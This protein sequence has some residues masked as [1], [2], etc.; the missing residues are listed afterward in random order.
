M[1]TITAILSACFDNASTMLLVAPTLIKLGELEHIDPRYMLLIA[2][3]FSNIG[4]C[5]TP[6]GDPPNLIIFGSPFVG[7]LQISYGTFVCYASPCVIITM[8]VIGVYLKLVYKSKESFR[9]A[10]PPVDDE[11]AQHTTCTS[12]P[13][14]VSGPQEV[15][16]ANTNV[17]KSP[18]QSAGDPIQSTSVVITSESNGRSADTGKRGSQVD[19][20]VDAL[21]A[22]LQRLDEAQTTSEL[23]LGAQQLKRRLAEQMHSLEKGIERKKGIGETHTGS[24]G[25]TLICGARLAPQISPSRAH[26]NRRLTESEL[27]LLMQTNSIKSWPILI[28]SMSVLTCAILF[29]LLQTLPN[30]KSTLGWVSLFAAIVLLAL[31]STTQLPTEDTLSGKLSKCCARS[32]DS[33]AATAPA[34]KDENFNRII[35]GVEW[36]TLMFFFALFI[37]TEVMV[38]LGVI[39]FVG[40][41]IIRLIDTVPSSGFR[42]AAGITI[43][44]WTTAVASALLDNVPFTTMMVKI[45]EEIVVRSRASNSFDP[46]TIRALI[47]ALAFGASYGGNGTAIGASANLVT[48]GVASNNGY[49]ISFIDYVKFNAPLAI[50]SLVVANIYLVLVFVVFRCWN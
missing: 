3:A 18:Q 5:G 45:V 15:R 23:S 30:I 34:N 7:S 19:R 47:Y 38:K 10:E 24:R 13:L 44:L 43:I 27:K 2:I 39:Q 22:C 40:A 8:A 37:V 41:Q 11:G 35:S 1:S 14:G 28:M 49:P 4:G 50:I 9:L 48:L 21:R 20:E 36:P 12:R 32:P 46:T 31:S 26:T 25:E 29:F 16:C 17:T 33:T 42:D 6:V